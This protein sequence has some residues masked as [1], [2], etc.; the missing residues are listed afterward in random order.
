MDIFTLMMMLIVTLFFAGGGFV[1]FKS[2]GKNTAWGRVPEGE[3]RRDLYDA[4]SSGDCERVHW[5]I[6]QGYSFDFSPMPPLTAAVKA[7]DPAM[8][9]LLLSAT[10]DLDLTDEKGMT[11]LMWAVRQGNV[12]MVTM[13]LGRGANPNTSDHLGRTPLMLAA[14]NCDGAMLDLLLERGAVVDAMDENDWD[15]LF[16]SV[17]GDCV[18]AVNRFL[19]LGL[20][21]KRPDKQ[22]Q[23]AMKLAEKKP[24][25]YEPFRQWIKSGKKPKPKSE[26]SP[27]PVKA[28]G[29]FKLAWLLLP[30]VL[31]LVFWA[32]NRTDFSSKMKE[33]GTIAEV[34]APEDV[35]IHDGFG[36]LPAG[37]FTMGC[38]PGDQDCRDD[39]LPAHEAYVSAF[40]MSQT[41]VSYAEFSRFMPKTGPAQEPVTQVSWYEAIAYCNWLSEVTGKEPVY[42]FRGSTEIPTEPNCKTD[43]DLS[44]PITVDWSANGFRLPTETEW[45]KAARFVSGA[46]RYPWGNEAPKPGETAIF[47]TSKPE[48]VGGVLDEKLPLQHMA[49]NV[50]EWVMDNYDPQAYG[51]VKGKDPCIRMGSSNKV[52]RG[53]HW[54]SMGLELRTSARLSA[55]PTHRSPTI[56]FRVCRS[57][58]L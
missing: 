25:I 54:Q 9:A 16:W 13:L 35:L 6:K 32:M 24:D 37:P 41:E 36:L 28:K 56:G 21:P 26:I 11:P 53:G 44:Y 38:A 49:G 4:I 58:G 51:K 42:R 43:C 34:S 23:T 39:E 20:D 47:A 55:P 19:D 48:N 18:N 2:Y 50:A 15:A 17:E 52:F 29:S 46:G 12:N 7:D 33:N 27:K 40:Y 8:L 45:E 14:S 5:Y 31:L 10:K 57:V 30:L 22:G 1:F 3:E